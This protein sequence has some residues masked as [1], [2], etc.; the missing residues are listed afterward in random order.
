MGFPAFL[1]VIQDKLQVPVWCFDYYPIWYFESSGNQES[2]IYEYTNS[3]N[4]K[5]IYLLLKR[6]FKRINRIEG[7]YQYLE[8]FRNQ[9]IKTDRPIWSVVPTQQLLGLAADGKII[10]GM[11]VLTLAELRYQA[12]TALAYGAQGIVYWRYAQADTSWPM[13][14]MR[15][16]VFEKLTFSYVGEY[17]L[18][19]PINWNDKKTPI[20]PVLQRLNSEIQ[21]CSVI[22]LESE[23]KGIVHTHLAK[24]PNYFFFGSKN[25]TDR[26]NLAGS[27]VTI[28]KGSFACL[29]S[30]ETNG[31]GVMISWITKD[32]MNFLVIVSHDPFNSQDVKMNIMPGVVCTLL[33]DPDDLSDPAGSDDNLNINGGTEIKSTILTKTLPPGGY[34]IIHFH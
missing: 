29:N 17:M 1:D 6:S 33:V 24:I 27:G 5:D 31:A 11:P 16:N 15:I 3:S 32:S 8:Y 9:S 23:V 25:T 26:E 19:T 10:K 22:F 34:M 30:I 2:E 20:W 18:T 28:I 12:F 13:A 7:F 21:R 4:N 14:D